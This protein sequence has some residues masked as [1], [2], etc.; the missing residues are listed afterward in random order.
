MKRFYLFDSL[1]GDEKFTDSVKSAYN[2]LKK[3]WT[4]SDDQTNKIYY[5]YEAKVFAHDFNL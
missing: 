3:H 1:T 4:V 5:A 2:H